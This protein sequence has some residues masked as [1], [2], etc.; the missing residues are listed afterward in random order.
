VR[1]EPRLATDPM[2]ARGAGASPAVDVEVFADIS[3]PFTHVGLRRFVER[4]RELDRDDVR[5]W[6]RAWP[7]EIVNAAPLDPDFIA[8]EIAQIRDECTPS[9]FTGFIASAFPATSMPAL[10]LVAAGYRRS[11]VDGEVLSLQLRDALFENGADITDPKVLEP[12]AAARHV[13]VED[14]DFASVLTDRRDGAAR[15]VIGSP[16]FFTPTADFFCP[17]LEVRRD[18]AGLLHVRSDPRSFDAF[19]DSCF[20]GAT[21]PAG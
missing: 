1:S 17:A 18:D 10:A 9:L 5:L 11:R 4:R 15:G 6:V 2:P 16:H 20:P 12:L 3:C 21:A 13:Q 7:L 19:I 14:Q 8:E